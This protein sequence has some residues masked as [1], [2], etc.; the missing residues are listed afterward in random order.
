MRHAVKKRALLVAVA[1]VV[2]AAV[3]PVVLTRTP[4]RMPRIR[5]E[6]ERGSPRAASASTASASGPTLAQ[7]DTVVREDMDLGTLVHHGAH[8][9]ERFRRADWE[10]SAK[11]EE[12]AGGIEPAFA[13]VRDR[14]GYDAY[15]GV[16]RGADGAYATRAG[17]AADRALMLARLL[18]AKGVRTRFA[19]GMLGQDERERLFLRTFDRRAGPA[20]GEKH[21]L[22]EGE[23][24]HQRLFRRARQD[25]DAVRTALGSRM[26][27][28]S[29]PSR[30]DVLAEMNPHVW[31]QAEVNG[32][33]IDLDPS[34]PD[35]E[36]GR[37]L[38]VVDRTPDSLPD[39][40][41]QRVT[42]RVVADHLTGGSVM[43]STLLEVTRKSVDLIDRPILLSHDKPMSATGIGSAIVGALGK[44]VHDSWM[45]LLWIDGEQTA[46]KS[47]DMAAPDFVAEW[48]EFELTWPNGRREVSR[49]ALVDRG[50]AA[51][52]AAA[53]PDGSAL[54]DVARDENGALAPRAI[55]NIW[56]SAGGHRLIDYADAARTL[57][58]EEAAKALAEHDRQNAGDTVTDWP[59]G[60]P[61]E[62]AFP[63]QAWPFVLQNFG[64]MIW[65]DHLILPLLNDTPGVRLYPDGPRI[66]IF[67][68][69]PVGEGKVASVVDLRRDDLRG[70]AIDATEAALVADM[71]MRFGV[72]QGALEHEAMAEFTAVV[73]GGSAGVWS[74]SGLLAGKRLAV[75][76]PGAVLSASQ[77]DATAG[78]S[79]AL[80][81]GRIVV[82]APNELPATQAWWEVVPE[83]GETRAVAGLGL[84][85]AGTP[86]LDRNN[87][88]L[89]K[90]KMQQNPWGGQKSWDART[91]REIRQEI[92]ETRRAAA[93]EK[94]AAEAAKYRNNLAP[95]QQGE[96]RGGGSEYAV[97]LTIGTLGKIAFHAISIVMLTKLFEEIE[98]LCSWLAEGGF[99]AGWP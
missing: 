8:L 27:P 16:L 77:D 87:P 50:G 47:V 76:A 67:T 60:Q 66:N 14:I 58:V 23:G 97:L 61:E 79:A 63:R 92:Y 3:V 35:A 89:I 62:E 31:L 53:H 9:A 15:A 43:A 24:F 72:L 30:D 13:F 32:R 96:A 19:I 2:G 51:W 17:N 55:H 21:R 11:A 38:A 59:P 54:R 95:P 39:E 42:I 84:R 90:R 74:T 98:L 28:V 37:A 71:K 10:L 64:F 48:L 82:A 44:S 29:T 6:K 25:Y 20:A 5:V 75:F 93:E 81:A 68:M 49:R 26:A 12:L 99:Q 41:F 18:E 70:V 56:L 65:T 34:L 45:P 69:G 52:R 88:F 1:L 46:G 80:A 57:I 22:D 73:T 33:W 78:I 40:L 94:A 85:G 91:E 36:P 86:P 4:G 83:T 7:D